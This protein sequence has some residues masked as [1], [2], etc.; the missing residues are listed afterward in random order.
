MA[1]LV[2]RSDWDH[3]SREK[4]KSI[5]DVNGIQLEGDVAGTR[6]T[7]YKG[8][9]FVRTDA[10]LRTREV[11]VECTGGSRLHIFSDGEGTWTNRVSGDP[12]PSLQGCVDVDIGITPATNTLPIKRLGLRKGQSR[13]TT[14]CY[15]PLPSQ[16][17]GEFLAQRAEQRYPCIEEDRSYLYQGI[18]RG[19]QAVLE[20][21]E[22][23]LVIDYPETFRRTM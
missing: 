13:D 14:V 1:K 21:D 11:V 8:H 15:A 16:T 18:F 6:D 9:Y 4:C 10:S 7:T 23:G 12:L 2:Q 22:V 20:I 17:G 19:F 3:K 5:H